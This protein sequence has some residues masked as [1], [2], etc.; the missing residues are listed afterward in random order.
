MK[1]AEEILS[2]S[3]SS[4]LRELMESVINSDCG[5]NV[6]I[7]AREMIAALD[8]AAE[9]YKPKWISVNE[10]L[11]KSGLIL[12]YHDGEIYV[13]FHAVAYNMPFTHWMPLPEPPETVKQKG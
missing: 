5:D 7:S 4:A 6:V 12:V 9:Q 2:K 10:R 1:S 8:D 3:A 13:H 11:P